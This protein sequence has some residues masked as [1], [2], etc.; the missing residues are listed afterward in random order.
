MAEAKKLSVAEALEQAEL[1]EGT[2]DRFEQTAPH[3]VEALGGR[4]ALAACSEMTCIG[5]M[6]R[7]DVATWAGMSREF[8]ERREWEARG[9]TRGTS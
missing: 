7:L 5:P 8:Q 4:D 1:I 9:N 6:P 2:L 3:A